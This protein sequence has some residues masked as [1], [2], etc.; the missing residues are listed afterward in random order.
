MR[1]DHGHVTVRVVAIVA[2]SGCDRCGH[3]AI[4]MSSRQG[5]LEAAGNIAVGL[6]ADIWTLHNATLPI[7]RLPSEILVTIF[8]A[9]QDDELPQRS[10]VHEI[11][12]TSLSPDYASPMTLFPWLRR[13]M[14][15]RHWFNISK[16]A[17]KSPAQVS[18]YLGRQY[19]PLVTSRHH[20]V[21][22]RP[23]T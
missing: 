3:M 22:P 21:P 5:H 15:C 8:K 20:L 10:L 14:V 18:T 17:I 9:V 12:G 7:M 23:R 19:P 1:V 16:S 4:L 6:S 13:L 2:A 11:P